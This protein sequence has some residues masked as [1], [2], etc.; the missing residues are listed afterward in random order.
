MFSPSA[1]IPGIGSINIELLATLSKVVYTDTWLDNLTIVC[2]LYSSRRPRSITSRQIRERAYSEMANIISRNW[3]ATTV[4]FLD[5]TK[6]SK[7]YC[8]YHSK[9]KTPIGFWRWLTFTDFFGDHI[10]LKIGL[11]LFIN[12]LLE[13]FKFLS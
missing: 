5:I 8:V 9:N 12:T 13:L 11:Q 6:L 1:F 3:R 10:S 4:Q 7:V 2:L